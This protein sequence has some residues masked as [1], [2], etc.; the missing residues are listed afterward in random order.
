[1]ILNQ[2]IARTTTRGFLLFCMILQGDTWSSLLASIQVDKICKEIETSGYGYR[3]MNSLPISMLALVDDLI[4]ITNADYRAQQM[5]IAINVKTA[6]KRLQFGGSKCKTIMVGKESDKINTN[7]L[8]VDKWKVEVANEIEN[9][10]E[11]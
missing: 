1:M 3:Y 5:N 4:G 11:C 6:E 7:P 8:M 9:N 2:K 10:P